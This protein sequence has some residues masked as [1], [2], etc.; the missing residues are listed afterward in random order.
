VL[1]LQDRQHAG[2]GG[3]V[4]PILP[5]SKHEAFAQC[6]A[7]GSSAAPAY[8]EAGY[9]D[10]RHSAAT[11]A[12]KQHILT[13]VSELQEEQLAIHQQTTAAAA[14]NAQVTLVSRTLAPR[15]RKKSAVDLGIAHGN[16]GSGVTGC[17]H[18]RLDCSARAE[19]SNNG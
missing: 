19:A 16:S 8:V 7:R 13:R 9:K 3:R 11:L 12:R 5:N 18:D 17:W 6:L 14:A 1:R 10:N 2:L 4:M 15:E